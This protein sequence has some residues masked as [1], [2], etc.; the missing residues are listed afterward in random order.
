MKP[1]CQGQVGASQS[2]VLLLQ[3]AG[4]G[5]MPPNLDSSLLSFLFLFPFIFFASPPPF[6]FFCTLKKRPTAALTFYL[7][8]PVPCHRDGAAGPHQTYIPASGSDP[9]TGDHIWIPAPL[10][11]T[12]H[13]V[14]SASL[15]HG[16]GASVRS[17][18][19]PLTFCSLCCLP[20]DPAEAK[21][22]Q[23]LS[24]VTL[25]VPHFSLLPLVPW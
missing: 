19:L 5:S 20:S 24:R 2:P 13:R 16:E 4:C 15:Q 23:G 1:L 10:M 21:D 17:Q 6:Y 8:Q 7:C 12:S 9:S 14:G 18:A 25:A 11:A 3:L 22:P